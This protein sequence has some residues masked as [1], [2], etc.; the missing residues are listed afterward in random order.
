MRAKIE[1]VDMGA[2]RCKIVLHMCVEKIHR[3]FIIVAAGNAGLIRDDQYVVPGQI[4]KAHS[5]RRPS[6]PFELFRLVSV[7]MIDVKN[8]ITIE[9]GGRSAHIGFAWMGHGTVVE[10]LHCACHR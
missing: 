2:M 9:K 3:R 7:A 10:Y 1:C 8:A 6:H 5:F 4:Q